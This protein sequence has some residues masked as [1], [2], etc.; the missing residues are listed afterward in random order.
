MTPSTFTSAEAVELAAVVRSGFVESRHIGSAVVL[1]PE[2]SPLISLGAPVVPGF[3]RSSLKPLQAI[4]AMNLGAD[5]S[6][7]WAA[8]ATAS[9]TCEAGHAE[10]VAGMLG[11]VGLS[12]A[13]LHCPSAHP[14]DGAF[15]RS[16]QEAGGDPKSALYF[17]CSGKHAA[18]LMAAT[19]IGATTTNYLQ[20]THPVQAKV[21]EVVEA[22]AGES[23]A[24]V[25]TDGCG[26]PVFVLSLVGLARAIGRV[27]RLGSADPAT[28]DANPMTTSAAEPYA[29][30][31]SEARTLMDA[32]FA[33]PWAIEGHGKPNTTVIDR[34]GVF[35]KG[36]AE[37]VIV[38]A[39]KSGYSVALKC[40]DGSS[41]ATGLVALTLLQKAGALPDVDDE[42]LDEVSAAITGPVTG[43]IDSEGRTAV[44]GRVIVGEDVARIRQEGESL[45]AIRRRIDPDEGRN[46]LEMWVA[47]SDADAAPADRQ[48]LATAVRF[49]LEELASRAEGNS[50]EVRVPPFGVTQCI[51]GPRHTR[52]TP[53]NVVETSAQ[54]WLEIV[55]GQTEFSAALA[56]GSV[57]ASGT[58]ADISDFVPLYT[59]AELEGRR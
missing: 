56:E 38:M 31:A 48:T 25:G 20:P 43:G 41:R 7:T 28:A 18:F 10:A 57:D 24:A 44:V 40:L 46:A 19:A 59:S 49:T 22:F 16:L 14:A 51:P 21:A 2:G 42:L 45:M 39:T 3:T 15:R 12:P 27:V 11:S 23:P 1:D 55:T 6:G 17:N 35:A 13:D 32:V 8:L 36:G 9:H 52:G 47:H 58:R 29:S 34:L 4:A 53:P 5:I 37:G 33:E 26:A 50:V 54:V 30:Y